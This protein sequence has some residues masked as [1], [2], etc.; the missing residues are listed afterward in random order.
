MVKLTKTQFRIGLVLLVLT[1]I[2]YAALNLL[3]HHKN[4]Q[5]HDFER[6][7]D[8][9]NE[10]SSCLVMSSINGRR[11]ACALLHYM[12]RG[13]VTC[14]DTVNNQDNN[15]SSSS[16]H[17]CSPENK[18][19]LHIVFMGDS[20]IRQQFLNFIKVES[21]SLPASKNANQYVKLDVAMY[22]LY[23]MYI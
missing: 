11:S 12:A 6:R 16:I 23:L 10:N 9:L 13:I 4:Q 5:K 2:F 7:V 8:E 17:H 14:L 19:L 20:R 15:S 18:G 21:Y 1:I 22:F 3:Y